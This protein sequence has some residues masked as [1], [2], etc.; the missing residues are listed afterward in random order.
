[1]G[2]NGKKIQNMF[3]IDTIF[4]STFNLTLEES[5]DAEATGLRFPGVLH[6]GREKRA[7]GKR[8]TYEIDLESPKKKSKN[9]MVVLCRRQLHGT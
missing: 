4:K 8:L 9:K 3:G 1:M 2:N 7:L 5:L 6:F